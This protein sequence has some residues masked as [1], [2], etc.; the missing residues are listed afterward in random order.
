M[1]RFIMEELQEV[2][3]NRTHDQD[4]A[5]DSN[6]NSDPIDGQQSPK[7]MSRLRK[8]LLTTQMIDYKSTIDNFILRNTKRIM[9]FK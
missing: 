4:P 1:D 3:D 8:L 5:V 2:S 6:V 7:I 9:L